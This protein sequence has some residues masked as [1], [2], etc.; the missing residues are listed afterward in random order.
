MRCLFFSHP[1]S[2]R[3]FTFYYT[4]KHKAAAEVRPVKDREG[5]E[6]RCV[7]VVSSFL[8]RRFKNSPSGT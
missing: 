8:S 6:G 5:E 4:D 2:Q 7:R 3:G 1:F